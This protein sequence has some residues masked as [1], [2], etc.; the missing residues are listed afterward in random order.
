M[1]SVTVFFRGLRG[2]KPPNPSDYASS[3]VWAQWRAAYGLDADIPNAD[4]DAALYG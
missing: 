4:D 1:A 2:A 3:R